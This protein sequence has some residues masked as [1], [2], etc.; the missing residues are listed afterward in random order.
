MEIPSCSLHIFFRNEQCCNY[1]SRVDA[2]P[3]LKRSAFFREHS[4]PACPSTAEEAVPCLHEKGETCV[5]LLRK[6]GLH[7]CCSAILE[8]V[9]RAPR[10]GVSSPPRGHSSHRRA[11]HHCPL[12]PAP[13]HPP[14]PRRLP[15]HGSMFLSRFTMEGFLPEP[16]EGAGG[17]WA[18]MSCGGTAMAAPGGQLAA[19]AICCSCMCCW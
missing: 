3:R 9:S 11:R 6:R 7:S 12:P 2:S 8:N 5:Q 17:G 10:I 15:P 13:L 14:V 1:R 16:G 4:P 19:A 18:C